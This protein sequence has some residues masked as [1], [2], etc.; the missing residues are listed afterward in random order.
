MEE[1]ETLVTSPPSSYN[2]VCDYVLLLWEVVLVW[3][4]LS[5]RE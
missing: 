3:V 2:Y 1:E 5:E 4:C